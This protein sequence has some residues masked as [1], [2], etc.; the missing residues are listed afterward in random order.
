LESNQIHIMVDQ[1][2]L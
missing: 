2:A 1:A